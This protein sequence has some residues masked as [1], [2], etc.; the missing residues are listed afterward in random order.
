MNSF[1]GSLHFCTHLEFQTICLFRFDYIQVGF[2][3]TLGK[4]VASSRKLHQSTRSYELFV[5]L[6]KEILPVHVMLTAN[7][8]ILRLLEK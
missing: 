6:Y 5:N 2:G 7:V 3:C 8:V 1:G 4:V